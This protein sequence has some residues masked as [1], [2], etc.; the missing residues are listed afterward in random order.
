[1]LNECKSRIERVSLEYHSLVLKFIRTAIKDLFNEAI[2]CERNKICRCII[3]RAEFRCLTIKIKNSILKTLIPEGHV[4]YGIKN[5]RF[6]TSWGRHTIL[7]P[8]HKLSLPITIA[9]KPIKLN[10]RRDER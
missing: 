10:N 5:K 6:G 7:V 4:Q 9:R 2:A 1:M 8:K 3:A